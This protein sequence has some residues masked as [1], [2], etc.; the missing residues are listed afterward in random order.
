ML[1]KVFTGYNALR[2][3]GQA[4]F[5]ITTLMGTHILIDP[6]NPQVGYPIAAHSIPANIVFVSHE[7]PDHNYVQAAARVGGAA[8]QDHPAPAPLRR[9]T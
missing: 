1:P 4:C 6:P 9:T 3:L 5:L 7:H 8:P 2:W